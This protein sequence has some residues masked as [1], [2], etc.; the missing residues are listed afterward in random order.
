MQAMQRNGEK[1]AGGVEEEGCKGGMI[2]VK[3]NGGREGGGR[4]GIWD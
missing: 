1:G 3:K 2:D 4:R